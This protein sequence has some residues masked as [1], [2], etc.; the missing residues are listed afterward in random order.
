MTRVSELAGLFAAVAVFLGTLLAAQSL[1]A[2]DS[3]E[4]RAELVETLD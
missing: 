4:L 1:V 2:R 3:L